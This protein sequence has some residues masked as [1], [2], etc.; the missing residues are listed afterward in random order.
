MLL[1]MFIK[2]SFFRGTL[3]TP[4]EK[5]ISAQELLKPFSDRE[6][7]VWGDGEVGG[8]KPLIKYVDSPEISS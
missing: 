4:P 8:E 7:G 2:H 1:K 3:K 5:A 6:M